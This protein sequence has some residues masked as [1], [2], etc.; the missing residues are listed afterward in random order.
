MKFGWIIYENPETFDVF[1]IST[2]SGSCWEYDFLYR[3]WQEV[4]WIVDDF[5][6]QERMF[7]TQFPYPTFDAMGDPICR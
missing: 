3:E 1:A 2:D 6:V 5:L 4:L 7:N